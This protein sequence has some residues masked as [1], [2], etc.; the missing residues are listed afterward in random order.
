MKF[1]WDEDKRASNLRKH[2]V[3]FVDAPLLWEGKMLIA[4]DTRADYGEQR[5]IG[6]G[7]LQGRVM[8]VVYTLREHGVVRIISFRKA[9][10]RE[11]DGY[12]KSVQG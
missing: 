5:W 1:E 2:G 9:N 12:E 6:A 10:S 4:E 11:V 7:K 8:I 3:D